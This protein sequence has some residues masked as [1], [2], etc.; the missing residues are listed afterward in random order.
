[1]LDVRL[2]LIIS[3][4]ISLST[5]CIQGHLAPIKSGGVRFGPVGQ[6]RVCGVPVCA[7]CNATSGNENVY[8]CT[9]HIDN[10]NGP[11]VGNVKW[12][13]GNNNKKPPTAAAVRSAEYS[14]TGLLILSQAYIKTSENTIEGEF[15]V[16]G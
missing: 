1:M 8:H 12:K 3:I 4:F 11:G 6:Q 9:D 15:Q 10:E 7:P 2:K 16:L 13:S 14:T 5:I